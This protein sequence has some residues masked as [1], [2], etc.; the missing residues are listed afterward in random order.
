MY[1]IITH[2]AFNIADPS[3]MQNTCHIWTKWVASRARRGS[4]VG[5]RWLEH[6]TNV[7]RV[8]GSVPDVNGLRFFSLSYS[9][10]QK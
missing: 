7:Q 4:F 3:S 5:L 6:L 1:L 10:G 9:A 8:M 2:V